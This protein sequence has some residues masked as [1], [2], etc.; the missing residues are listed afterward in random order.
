MTLKQIVVAVLVVGTCVLLF[1]AVRAGHTLLSVKQFASFWERRNELP[2]DSSAL[3]MVVLGDS[4]AQ[5]IGASSALKGFV[6]VV[7]DRIQTDFSKSVRLYNFSVSGAVVSDVLHKQLPLAST[8][9]DADIVIIAVGPN[10]IIRLKNL[11][12]S[13]AEYAKILDSLAIS[14][15]KIV[16]ANTPP[17]DRRSISSTTIDQWNANIEKLA[18][19]SGVRV[20]DIHTVI[21]PRKD[22]H[23]IY[24]GDFF[25][26]SNAGYELWADAFMIEVSKVLSRLK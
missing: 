21:L 18:K 12:E 1:F 4:T 8:L 17:L 26:P 9:N 2:V 6:G 24:S 10:D 25:H 5:G 19:Q 13:L 22:D 16:I 7:S 3:N 11:D 15:E 20:A 23:R 14:P